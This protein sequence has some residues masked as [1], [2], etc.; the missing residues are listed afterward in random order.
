M[1]TKHVENNNEEIYPNTPN[2]DSYSILK[3]NDLTHSQ[4]AK[5][6]TDSQKASC[7]LWRLVRGVRLLCYLC[8]EVSWQ[9]NRGKWRWT[10]WRENG[11]I[12]VTTSSL[13]LLSTILAPSTPKVSLSL[14]LSVWLLRKT[15]PEKW[16]FKFWIWISYFSL[17]KLKIAEQEEMI[18]SFEKTHA[19]QS[20]LWRVGYIWLFPQSPKWP[21]LYL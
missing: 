18:R 12:L 9:P 5:N 14:S 2:V 11:E 16:N 17:T 21:P 15:K 7:L 10:N 6:L 13:S 1:I 8:W 3:F 4:K 20:R 19:Q